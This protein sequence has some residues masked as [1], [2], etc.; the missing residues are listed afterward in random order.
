VRFPTNE[1]SYLVAQVKTDEIIPE[2]PVAYDPLVHT[3]QDP[4]T[5]PGPD[6][7]M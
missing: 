6:S 4:E 3:Y 7:R 2:G 5:T 1:T